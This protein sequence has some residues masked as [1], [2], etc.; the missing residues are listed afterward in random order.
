VRLV[1]A[2]R[3]EYRARPAP[4]T[5]R[6]TAHPV[7]SH[8]RSRLSRRHFISRHRRKRW[9]NSERRLRRNSRVPM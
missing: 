1:S 4:R 2:A 3:A 5:P 7:I 9:R 8:M 6:Q